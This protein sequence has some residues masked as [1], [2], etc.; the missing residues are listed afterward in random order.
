MLDVFYY[1]TDLPSPQKKRTLTFWVRKGISSYFIKK[2]EV[3]RYHISY[4]K[5]L[6]SAGAISA[7]QRS[8]A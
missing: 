4:S 1:S 8:G 2:P 6:R 3:S 7:A 5:I